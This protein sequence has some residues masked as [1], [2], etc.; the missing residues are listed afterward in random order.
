[1]T[2][3]LAVLTAS[4]MGGAVAA[5]ACVTTAVP[6]ANAATGTF[7]QQNPTDIA[8][9]RSFSSDDNTITIPSS[10]PASAYPAPIQVS[11]LT[12]T[13]TDV[14]VRLN[15]LN[16]PFPS[17]LDVMLVG[18]GGQHVVLMSDAGGN[19][20]VVD[21]TFVIDDEAPSPLPGVG[22]INTDRYQPT[23][24]GSGDPF[25]APA[26]ISSDAATGLSAFDGTS[27]NGVWSLYVVDDTFM[28]S[29]S[30]K[31]GWSLSIDTSV[32]AQPY[33]STLQVAGVHGSVTDVD[34][35]LDGLANVVLAD[36]DLLLV[37]PGGQRAVVMSDAG[38]FTPLPQ[39]NLVLDDEAAYP[40]F[41]V[42]GA[43]LDS[44]PADAVRQGPMPAVFSAAFRPRDFDEPGA[45]PD[46]FSAP[47][48]DTTG[49]GSALSVFDGTDPNGPWRLFAMN[50]GWHSGGWLSGWSLR[51]STTDPA[52]PPASPPATTPGP[53]A[54]IDHTAPFVIRRSPMTT[55]AGVA[56]GAT[57]RAGFS[58]AMRR[59]SLT[60]TT[61]RLSR[62]HSTRTVPATVTYDARR[63]RVLLDPAHALRH[64]TT[65]LVVVT[66]GARDLAGN[67]L[68]Q[69]PTRTGGQRVSWT[70]RTR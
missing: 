56:T 68:D 44:L 65:Y 16:H 51:L 15:T 55:T 1:M 38:T 41:S 27:P 36:L 50:D 37:G 23:N 46:L 64:R 53:T 25:P 32:T 17:D 66:T 62:A 26:P 34:L 3:L 33:P 59:A 54:A 2:R 42:P 20:A 60:G 40:L 29:G 43:S 39:L 67:R 57:I 70:F 13:I 22:Q 12:G 5:V 61:V 6:A 49:A 21:T 47:A 19:V 4:L 9:H 48:P 63:H 11:G 69:D 45:A 24:Y 8:A 58:E 18:P 30:L 31:D 10:G 28:D 7:S 52:P 35:V 14:D